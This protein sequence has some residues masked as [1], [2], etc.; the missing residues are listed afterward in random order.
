M[1]RRLAVVVIVLCAAIPVA[2]ADSVLQG[3]AIDITVWL[4]D[5]D[6]INYSLP[7]T[8]LEQDRYFNSAHCLCSQNDA[9]PEQ[10]FAAHLSYNPAPAAAV[11]ETVEIWTGSDCNDSQLR[12]ASCGPDPKGS[13]GTEAINDTE[14][15]QLTVAQLLDPTASGSCPTVEQTATIWAI[16]NPEHDA[17]IEDQFTVAV[18]S[19]TQAPPSP[20]SFDTA[21]GAESAIELSWP[22]IV[23]NA[24]DI[25]YYQVL[26]GTLNADGE[27]ADPAPN[28]PTQDPRYQ[29][30]RDLCDVPDPFEPTAI[31]LTTPSTDAP[32]GGTDAFYLPREL[33]QYNP[34]YI[35]GETNGNATGIR[36]DGLENGVPYY[37]VL[38]AVDRV[39]NF[40]AVTMHQTLT[41]RPATDFWEDLQNKGSNV[42]GG[43]CLIADTY[44]D[45]GGGPGGAITEGLRR[46]RD[47]TLASSAAGRWLTARYYADVAPLGALVRRSMIARVAFAIVLLP[48]VAVALLWHLLTLPGLIALSLLLRA[49]W[50]AW[51]RRAARPVGRRR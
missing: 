9:G 24:S 42:E 25:E 10:L 51:R 43:F 22:T 35:C 50:C 46:F 14:N 6:G 47:E 7:Q 2:S 39:G 36:I 19:D 38:L 44:G 15:V 37:F 33:A 18:D 23:S 29:S 3:G 11:S 8:T 21:T 12:D 16:I 13:V 40:S 45:G 27:S 49:G 17:T 1:L 20:V 4:P 5:S 26:C 32:D 30:S 34:A 41:P 48:L 28:S 31:T